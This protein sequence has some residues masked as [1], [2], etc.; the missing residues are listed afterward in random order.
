MAA[1]VDGSAGDFKVGTPR[2][3]FDASRYELTFGVSPDPT[4]FLMMPLLPPEAAPAQV[5][6]VL[7]WAE[8]LRQRL[9]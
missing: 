3:L 8:E 5:N 7:N 4:R 9:K 2:R 1:A 6:I